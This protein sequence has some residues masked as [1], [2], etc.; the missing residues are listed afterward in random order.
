MLRAVVRCPRRASAARRDRDAQSLPPITRAAG[1]GNAYRR[2]VLDGVGSLGH[3]CAGRFTPFDDGPILTGQHRFQPKLEAGALPTGV[4]GAPK[5]Y[6]ANAPPIQRG[7]SDPSGSPRLLATMERIGMPLLIHGEVSRPGRRHPFDREGC[8]SRGRHLSGRWLARCPGTGRW[9]WKHIHHPADAVAFCC[10]TAAPSLAAT[11]PPHHHLQDHRNA[12]CH[13]RAAAPWP[14]SCRWQ[15]G[16]CTFA[17]PALGGTSG[18]PKF[19]SRHRF[20]A[21]TPAVC[22]ESGPVAAPAIRS[23]PPICPGGKL[24]PGV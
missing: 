17:G 1:G 5:L 7:V 11:D 3:P 15:T 24:C 4:F 18:N 13:G 16:I 6:P 10:R 2:T 23:M 14:I 22:K 8:V 21:A 9:C 19:F 12:M 20:S